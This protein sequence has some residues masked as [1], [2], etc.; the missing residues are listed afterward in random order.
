MSGP[1]SFVLNAAK[2]DTYNGECGNLVSDKVL[3]AWQV[4]STTGDELYGCVY[5]NGQR[6]LTLHC[7]DRLCCLDRDNALVL[8][9][10]VSN[11]GTGLAVGGKSRDVV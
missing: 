5:F 7:T 4:C 2:R 1:V 3:K 10:K 9:F 11:D 6:V 8:A